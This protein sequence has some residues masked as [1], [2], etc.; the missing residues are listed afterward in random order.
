MSV[1]PSAPHRHRPAPSLPPGSA[2]PCLGSRAGRAP[3]AP[4]GPPS[5]MEPCPC[6]TLTWA[7]R[8][9]RAGQA[10]WCRL[11]SLVSRTGRSFQY[12]WL[13]RSS[14]RAQWCPG[15]DST[16]PAGSQLGQGQPHAPPGCAGEQWPR[17]TT[18][19][20]LG[21]RRTAAVLQ[22]RLAGQGQCWPRQRLQLLLHPAARS[23]SRAG[24]ISAGTAF[25]KAK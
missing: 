12:F 13:C 25:I 3:P 14:A 19:A 10:G 9:L 11:L 16:L 1:S 4:R 7:P 24:S 5:C 18:P 6:E 22:G 21:H 2:I 17:F 23:R 8:A 20:E 15:P